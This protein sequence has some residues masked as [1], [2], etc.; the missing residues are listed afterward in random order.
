M[1]ALDRARSSHKRDLV[2]PK[3]RQ[4]KERIYEKLGQTA[5]WTVFPASGPGNPPVG[6]GSGPGNQG[7]NPNDFNAGPGG[8]GGPGLPAGQGGETQPHTFS[9]PPREGEKRS[10]LSHRLKIH[11]DHPDHQD[12]TKETNGLG[13]S[14]YAPG[15]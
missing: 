12:Q 8:P 3:T 7:K 9:L 11:P 6:P 10:T 13:W 14:G 5:F 15:G 4:L 1:R 2:G